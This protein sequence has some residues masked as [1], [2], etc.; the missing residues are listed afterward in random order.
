[1]IY[2]ILYSNV[3]YERPLWCIITNYLGVFR[4]IIFSSQGSLIFQALFQ[5]WKEILPG[6]MFTIYR[7]TEVGLRPRYFDLVPF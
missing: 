3:F 5:K 1:M 4:C 7:Q 6:R 2:L